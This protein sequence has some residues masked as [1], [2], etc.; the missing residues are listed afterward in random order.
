MVHLFDRRWVTESNAAP[1]KSAYRVWIEA[2]ADQA[3]RT[4]L[5]ANA[6]DASSRIYFSA[7]A[8]A[9]HSKSQRKPPT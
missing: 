9:T 3:F 1:D 8:A 4:L 6:P 7:E 2:A 5:A